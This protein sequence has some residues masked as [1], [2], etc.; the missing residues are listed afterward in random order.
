MTAWLIWL[1]A[2]LALMIVEVMTGTIAAACLSAGCLWAIVAA[3]SG[4]SL[5]LQFVVAAVGA[6]VAFGVI[7][8]LI[9]KYRLNSSHHSSDAS[10]MD[11]I[12]GRRGTVTQ[13]IQEGSAGRVRI[14]GDSWQAVADAKYCPVMT[15]DTVEV[16]SYDSIIIKVRPLKD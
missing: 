9:R 16:E 2:A 4:G 10:N 6:V 7:P 3:V 15:G 8:P 1:I 11:A 5:V 14:D 12:I 13:P